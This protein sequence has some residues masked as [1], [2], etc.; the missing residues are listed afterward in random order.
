MPHA[1]AAWLRMDSATNL[2]VINSLMWFDETPNWERLRANY[3]ERIVDRFP[4]FRLST[5]ENHE[6]CILV[7]RRPMRRSEPSGFDA[8]ASRSTASCS[9]AGPNAVGQQSTRPS[10]C[11]R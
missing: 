3:I 7:S 8:N 1:D 6:L 2:M 11:C 9:I 4:R 10:S 5:L